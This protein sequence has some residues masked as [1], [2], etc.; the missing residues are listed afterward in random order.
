MQITEQYILMQAPNAKAADNGRKLSQKGNFG[1]LGKNAEENVYWGECSGSGKNPYKT[2]IDWSLS[3]SAP[4]CRCSCPSRQFPCKH[5]LGLMF[6][7][8]AGKNFEVT[9]M[10]EDLAEKREKQAARAAKKE[11]SKNEPA[12]PKKTNTAAQKKKIAK[13]LEGLDQAEKMV[14]EL[15]TAGIGTLAGSSAQSFEKLAKDLGNYYLTGP[16]T[17]FSRIALAVKQI[18]KKPDEA[19]AYYAEALRILVYLHATIKK[20]RDFLNNKLEAENFSSED[21]VLF[22]AMGGIWKLDDLHSIGAYRENARLVQMSFDVSFDEAKKEYV[23]RGFWMD[24][25]NGTIAQTLNYRPM[26]ALKYVK[27]DDSCFDMVEVPVLY[28]YPGELNRR[29]RWDGYTTR[30]FTED[31]KALIPSL[32]KSN[33]AEAVKVAKNQM[34]NTLMPKYVPCFLPI[35]ELGMVED[36]LVLADTA[37]NRIELRDRKEDG[38]DH[39]TTRHLKNLPFDISK[40]CSLFG[41]MFY[42]EADHSICVHPYSIATPQEIIRLQY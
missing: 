22:E 8:L 15:L 37:G 19:D 27:A 4:T 25:D 39:E 2:S 21:T 5:S 23:E 10:P 28:E 33:I 35:G 1:N 17:A 38:A 31:E 41:I 40:N 14:D 20:S 3:E 32:A 30:Q 18:Q 16:Q 13:Q 24:I 9:D 42:D 36:R 26:K 7:M 34:K 11:E 6:E 29:I 12:K